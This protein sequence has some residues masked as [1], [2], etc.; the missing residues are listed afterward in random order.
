MIEDFKGV[1]HD[2]LTS[3][4][5]AVLVSAGAGSGKTTVMIEKIADL[6]INKNVPVNSLLVVTFT[7]LAAEEMKE[8]LIEKLQSLLP[9][10]Q[11]KEKI[12]D[13]IEQVKT[14]N[15]DTI[16]G[17]SSKTIRKYFYALEINPNIEIIS[18][19]TRDY[20][21]SI[22][23]KKTL[24]YT[25]ANTDKM[26]QL[27]DIF[28]GDSR[29]L[30]TLSNL[31]TDIYYKLINIEDYNQFLLDALNE[32]KTGERTTKILK[33]KILNTVGY[34]KK[35]AQESYS[36]LDEMLQKTCLN[37]LE[38]LNIFKQADDL[39]T[40]LEKLKTLTYPELRGKKNCEE[41]KTAIKLVKD[42]AKKMQTEGIDETYEAKNTEI[43]EYLT[44]FYEVLTNFMHNYTLIKQKNN[45]IDFN[46]LNRLMLKLLANEKVKAELQ[47]QF[48]FVFVDEYQDVNPL[49]DNL[50]GQLIGKDTKLFLVGDVKQ[51]IYGFRG[52]NPNSFL[53]RYA[54]YKNNKEVGQAFNMNVNYRSNPKIM[55]FVNDVFARIMTE[56]DADINYGDDCMIEPQRDDIKDDKV[57]IML[58]K[59]KD[60]PIAKNLYSVKNAKQVEEQNNEAVLVLLAITDLINKPFYD[61]KLKCERKLTYKDIA[62]LSRS[63]EDEQ[64][65]QLINFLRQNNVPLKT[66]TKLDVAQNEGV[67]LI[68]S[69]LKCVVGMADDVD[70]LATLFALT[71]ITAEDVAVIKL[72]ADSFYNGL[73]LSS[74][75]NVKKG[76]NYLNNIYE[77]S[78]HSTNS[79]LI[80]YILN[81]CALRYNLL[82]KPNGEVVVKD[83][84]EFIGKLSALEDGLNLAEFIKVIESSKNQAGEVENLD[85]ENSV[86]VQTIH[87]SKGLEYPVVIL[88][89]TA[90]QFNYITD[91]SLI[92][93]NTE[94]GLGV[95]YYNYETRTKTNSVQRFVIKQIND[96][97]GYKEEMRLLYVALTRAKNKL[98]ITG[99][100]D[101]KIFEE[102]LKPSN[103]LNMLIGGFTPLKEGENNFENCSI[104]VFDEITTPKQQLETENRKITKAYENFVY[105]NSEKF[106]IPLK[107]TVTGL[108]SEH[109]ENSGFYTK[110]IAQT[111]VQYN[112][113]EDRALIGTHY[114][115]AL[116]LL[117]LDKPYKQN[118]SF[119]DVDYKKIETAH[120]M[121]SP[122]V[123]DAHMHKEAEFMMYVPY[124]QIVDSSVEDK[125]LVQG[126]V[127]LIIEKEN[128]ITIVD[129]KFSTKPIKVLKQR[130]SEQ[131][132][133]YKL[134]VEQAFNKKVENIYIYSINTGELG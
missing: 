112:A 49:Q 37:F 131:L 58:A 78:L 21:I 15:I 103:F 98:I 51:S 111:H 134:A 25:E 91:N 65:H 47:A 44:N 86:T 88:Y 116:E 61:A 97:K 17:F 2:I 3:K 33:N 82:L 26:A 93:F 102:N 79:E 75:G 42:F 54:N 85:E 23:L 40:L 18:D 50:L 64:A 52:A 28:G 73:K 9:T 68:L 7:V 62:I 19:A 4:N 69:V 30:N 106:N 67:K 100:Y 92:N 122:L 55:R 127:D 107:N 128:S 83:I 45:L 70:Y 117:E 53:N 81:D 126:V 125:V 115:K 129:Y 43:C 32:Y 6:I 95:D 27:L 123:K 133:L 22:A 76:F 94:L 41:L 38:Q 120:K 59:T 104:F 10:A 113:D 16:D 36:S 14:A 121:L 66:S 105:K 77:Y 34:A 48:K 130:Y 99:T 46:D 13:L 71:D 56:A 87:K 89:N 132:N 119:G 11:D 108:N 24:D 12:L 109:S 35:L 110:E 8:R 118:S 124:N 1:Q 84:E 20:Y 31:I 74:N 57:A 96:V 101:D 60:K 5:N 29:N 72:N 63:C 39:K 80:C 114:H 90:K